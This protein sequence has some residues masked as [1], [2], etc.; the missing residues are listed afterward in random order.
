MFSLYD[1]PAQVDP[2]HVLNADMTRYLAWYANARAIPGEEVL[3]PGE[4]ERRARA[5]R[6]T[7]GV[8]LPDETWAAIVQT[9]RDVGVS[10][11]AVK[12]ATA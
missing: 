10:E 8:P 2:A 3:T 7:S 11:E 9:A 4:P 6:T 12:N 5:S 1:D